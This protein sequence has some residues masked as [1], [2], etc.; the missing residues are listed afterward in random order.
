MYLMGSFAQSFCKTTRLYI[1]NYNRKAP[2]VLEQRSSIK[3][4]K[5]NN[6]RQACR[7]DFQ[8]LQF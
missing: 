1:R 5:G 2:E 3:I 4:F 8:L 7:M 6:L